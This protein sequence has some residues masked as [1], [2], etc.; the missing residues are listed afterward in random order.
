MSGIKKAF[1]PDGLLNPGI[2]VDAAPLTA[3]LRY[4]VHA[5][6]R[7]NLAMAYATDGGDF[8]QAVH[9]CT[10]VGKC[11]ADNTGSGGVMCPSYQATKEEIHSTRGRARLLQEIVNGDSDITWSSP[12][13]HEALDLCLACKGCASDCPTGTDMASLQGRGA[14]PDLQ[15]QVCARAATTPWA[16][17]RAGPGSARRCRASPTSRWTSRRCARSRSRRPAWTPGG[18]CRRSR[19]VPSAGRSSRRRPVRRSCSS[20]TP[21]PT[22]SP[23]RW[24]TQPH[25]CSARRAS[26]RGSPASRSAA[27]CPGSAPVRLDGAAKRL[28]SMVEALAPD[29]RE[30]L[31]VVG[32]E[33]SCTAVLRHEPDRAWCRARTPP[34]SPARR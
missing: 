16:G 13:V 24:R 8:G 17:C 14:A 19:G 1:D 3:D 25:R 11:R 9:R 10:G 5:G 34:G 28:R 20:S 7:K 26:R 32:L 2:I 27:D 30:G 4:G 6:L 31:Q 15:E 23:P 18:G 33:P 21:S 12:A 22:T 29:V